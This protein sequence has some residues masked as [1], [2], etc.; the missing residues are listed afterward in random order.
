MANATKTVRYA[1]EARGL[2]QLELARRA[3]ISRQALGAI[4]AGTYQPGVTV[5]I[6]LARELG[7]SV[8]SLFGEA[9]QITSNRI[10]VEWAAAQAADR[11][12]LP[13]RVALA[14]VGGKVVAVEQSLAQLTLP[15]AAG[16]LER[17]KHRRAKVETFRTQEEID[18]TLL[19]A[20][21]DPA[22][23]I[24]TDWLVR[25][26]APVS[27]IA[28]PCSSSRALAM[29]IEGRTHAAGVH[30]KDPGA[31]E[32]NVASTRTA[33]SGRAARVVAFAR[34]ELGLATTV[35]N[36]LA[37]RGVADLARVGVRLVNR[38]VGAGARAFLD[39]ALAESGTDGKRIEG[40][41]IEVGGHLEVAAAIAAGHANV[42]VTIRLA[43]D[44]YGLPFVPM[45]EERYDL[46]ILERDLDSTPVKAMLDALNSRR[47]AREVS[48]FC[49]Y[50]TSQMGRIIARI[51]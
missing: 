6:A 3:R 9:G 36:R 19:I 25:H 26:R 12:P 35:G 30:L 41:D 34:W 8:E 29:L 1:R 21:C 16:M 48:Q 47:F 2:T 49:A 28:L 44:T 10:E 39:D 46:V 4:E 50:D 31:D 18:S 7:Q 38:E 45:R 20:G 33:L 40:Y 11:S 51:G 24:L 14:R 5:A 27:A 17:T 43:A 13:C 23:T 37:I 15:A 22:V 32:Y 42:G